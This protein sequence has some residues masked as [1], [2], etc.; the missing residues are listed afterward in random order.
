MAAAP[1]FRTCDYTATM[2]P[3][4]RTGLAAGLA[5]AAIAAVTAGC[6]GGTG[7]AVALDPVAAAATKTQNA[8]AARIHLTIALTSPQSHGTVELNG[9]GAIDGTSSELS[10]GL[11]SLLKQTGLPAAIS[12]GVPMAELMHAKVKEVALEQHGDY[13]LYL[14]LG[15]LASQLPGGKQWIELDLTKVGKSAGIDLSKVMSGAQF[16]PTDLLAMAKSE[17][18]TVDKVG[19]AKVGGV[20]TTRYH[21]SVD[22][23]KAL[24]QN[25]LS[26]PALTAAA[27]KVKTVSEN[28]WIDKSGLVRRIRSSYGNGKAHVAMTMNLSDYGSHV[29]VAAPASDSVYDATQLVQSFSGLK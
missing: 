28:V 25:G 7:S 13:V 23:A 11:G 26:N 27:A 19:P 24:K 21:V 1:L 20:A 12:A 2:I 8:G 16:Q 9:R 10:F 14:N 17:G 4:R 22:V 18:A 15:S 29:T 3:R 6:G 5:V